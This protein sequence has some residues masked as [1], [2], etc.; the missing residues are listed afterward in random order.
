LASQGESYADLER[1]KYFFKGFV[2]P[3]C[4]ARFRDVDLFSNRAVWQ[5]PKL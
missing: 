2:I 1:A 5:P 4:L 3:S